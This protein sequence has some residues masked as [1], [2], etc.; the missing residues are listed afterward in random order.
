MITRTLLIASIALACGGDSGGSDGQFDLVCTADD[1]ACTRVCVFE[2]EACSAFCGNFF[3][4]DEITVHEGG[5]ERFQCPL[6]FCNWKYSARLDSCNFNSQ[7]DF[8]SHVD[9]DS[10]GGEVVHD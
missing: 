10:E 7:T 1:N 9:V 6:E 5:E 4:L 8:I 3:D 2:G